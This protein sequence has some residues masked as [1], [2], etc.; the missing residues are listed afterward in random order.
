M[1]KSVNTRIAEGRNQ[2]W[3]EMRAKEMLI[4]EL[5]SPR[6][7]LGITQHGQRWHW[8]NAMCAQD[9][10]RKFEERNKTAN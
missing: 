3:E 4:I 8:R 7:T 5:R 6:A 1:A 2:I 10:G 9:L